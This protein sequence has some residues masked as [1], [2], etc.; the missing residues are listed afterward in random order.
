MDPLD[1]LSHLRSGVV[2]IEQGGT[3]IRCDGG[4]DGLVGHC[5]ED[6]VGKNVLDFVDPGDVEVIAEIFATGDDAV[7]IL[8]V[9]TPF[10]IRLM[11]ADGRPELV[12]VVPT[13]VD[14]ES[15]SGWVLSLT[16]HAMQP[17]PHA[18][19]DTIIRG[20]SSI[21]ALRCV[22]GRYELDTEEG[23]RCRAFG[24]LPGPRGVEVVSTDSSPLID[25][26]A[27]AATEQA[28][29]E[30][31]PPTEDGLVQIPV[32]ELPDAVATAAREEGFAAAQ[33]GRVEVGDGWAAV[34]W[35]VNDLSVGAM[36]GNVLLIRRA[37]L[38]LIA[39]ILRQEQA[40]EILRYAAF[41]DHLTGLANRS[42]LQQEMDALDDDDV[43]AVLFVD[44]DDFKAVNDRHGHR[45]GDV[46]LGEIAG[47]L[48]D[49]SRPNGVVA[50]MGGD[51][52][53]VLLTDVERSEAVAIGERIIQGV[54]RSL[55][56]T[57][58]PTSVEVT[59]GLSGPRPAAMLAD[60]MDEADQAMLLGKGTRDGRSGRLV[61]AGD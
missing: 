46:V 23:L 27:S 48:L 50:R 43:I 4:T 57:G 3:I 25:A 47:R 10:S 45:I 16:P 39:L 1:L 44:V 60:V 55:E 28:P 37:I 58:G 34:V 24:L 49:A 9:P 32:E 30:W 41:H 53:A 5:P 14:E 8:R 54:G 52:F 6:L 18:V 42:G 7:R 35:F 11:N 26:L 33:L 36:R 22:V 29:S 40:A 20:G 15:F 59:V 21:D 31:L 2:A 61:V 12:D 51:E 17:I 13:G 19:V 38:R 56:I